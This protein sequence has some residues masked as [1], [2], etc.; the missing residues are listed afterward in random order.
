MFVP[1]LKHVTIRRI[2]NGCKGLYFL[3][4]RIKVEVVGFMFQPF[5]LWKELL[6]PKGYEAGWTPQL[7]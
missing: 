1:V 5:Y 4:L 3:N 6:F 2:T 7:V